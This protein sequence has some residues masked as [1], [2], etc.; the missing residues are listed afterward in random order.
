[1]DHH[2]NSLAA[3]RRG[4]S[5]SRPP[6]MSVCVTLLQSRL[7]STNLGHSTHLV[8]GYHVQPKDGGISDSWTAKSQVK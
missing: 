6:R 4:Q 8:A 1:M 3:T 5:Q 7:V 2:G